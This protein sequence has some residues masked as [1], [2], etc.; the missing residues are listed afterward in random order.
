MAPSREMGRS[1][2]WERSRRKGD[3]TAGDPL[4]LARSRANRAYEDAHGCRWFLQGSPNVSLRF[5]GFHKAEWSTT[6]HT[7]IDGSASIDRCRDYE[8]ACMGSDSAP[9]RGAHRRPG[10]GRLSAQHTR[11]RPVRGD[12]RGRTTSCGARPRRPRAA[13][14]SVKVSAMRPRDRRR[15]GPDSAAGRS[16]HSVERRW[17]QEPLAWSGS[18]AARTPR[19]VRKQRVGAGIA[20]PVPTLT[21]GTTVTASVEESL[22]RSRGTGRPPAIR[23]VLVR[24]R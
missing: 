11:T 20:L 14:V 10:A 24:V 15:V 7:I 3:G 13:G 18:R 19:C 1:L 16:H 6:V 2:P 9:H 8:E 4:W 12:E 17:N 23:P 5:W 21:P 22:H